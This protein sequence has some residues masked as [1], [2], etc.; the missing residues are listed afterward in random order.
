MKDRFFRVETK[1][2]ITIGYA[3][4]PVG[5]SGSRKGGGEYILLTFQFGFKKQGK[6]KRQIDILLLLYKD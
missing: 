3:P 5:I 2:C 1:I 6:I 4:S